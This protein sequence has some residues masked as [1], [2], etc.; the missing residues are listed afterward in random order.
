MKSL[1]VVAAPLAGAL[2]MLGAAFAADA[3]APAPPPWGNAGLL[4][5]RADAGGGFTFD[6]GVL[7]GRLRAGGKS[8]GLTGVIHGETGARL[9]RSNGLLSHY[10]V[11]ANGRRFGAG[12]W[13]WPGQA[14]LQ[15]DGA[16]RVEWPA[17]EERPFAMR[18]EYRL[19]RP[20]VVAVETA[21]EAREPLKDF[22][23]FL[24]SYFDA[25][26]TNSLVAAR[27]DGALEWVA[28]APEAGEWQMFCRDEA[29]RV[30]ASD[31]R[32]RLEPHPVTWSFPAELAGPAVRA[33]RKAPATGLVATF[34][35]T[36]ADCF[37]VATPHQ[38]EGHYS[39]YLS[40]FGRTLRTGESSR[41]GVSLTLAGPGSPW[42]RGASGD[43]S[44]GRD[45]G[46]AGGQRQQGR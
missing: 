24:A 29:A 45:G 41:A 27:R 38:Y 10:R 37:A 31:G 21:V 20:G 42:R 6:T 7:R 8:L 23:V 15:E 33:Q 43:G 32:W 44:P 19:T 1:P 26:F 40:L 2:L 25:A 34:S 4:R 46:V 17:T 12:A 5:F 30:L 22:E 9:D 16:V 35:T 39:M 14:T 18:A 36:T 3:P 11:F 13:D 28:A